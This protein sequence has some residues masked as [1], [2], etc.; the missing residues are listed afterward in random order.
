MLFSR[1]KNGAETGRRLWFLPAI[2]AFMSEGIGY[3]IC[4][5]HRIAGF[6]RETM[7]LNLGGAGRQ[8]VGNTRFN[9]AREGCIAF[10]YS[11][12]GGME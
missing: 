7:R 3:E 2:S 1:A 11:E 9:L 4:V 12:K 10:L 8:M 5:P 6:M